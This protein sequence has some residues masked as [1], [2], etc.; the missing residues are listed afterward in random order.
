MHIFSA[1]IYSRGLKFLQ[2][3][4]ESF[5]CDL[6]HDFFLFMISINKYY[7]FYDESTPVVLWL[8]YSPLDLR[9][10]GSNPVGIDEFFQNVKNLEYDYLRKGSKGLGS[11]VIDLRHV[12]EPQ[13]EIRDSEQNLSHFSRSL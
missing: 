7:I 2:V 11:R 3:I 8:S 12:K 9:F 4:Y 13:A 5:D 10:V 1:T 6:T